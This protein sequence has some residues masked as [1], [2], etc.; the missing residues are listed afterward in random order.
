M[1]DPSAFDHYAHQ[2]KHVHDHEPG[3]HDHA[4]VAAQDEGPPSEYEIMSRAMQE[5]LEAK[6][7]ITAEEVRRRMETFEEEFP[8]RG[9]RVIAHAWTDPAF[10]KRLLKDG[11]AACAEMGVE[12]EADRLIAV[13][14]MPE[15]HNLIVCTLCSCYPR[16]LLGMP[17]TWYKSTNYRSRVVFEPRA[18][19]KEF[20]TV[21]PEHVTV[22]VHDSNADMRYVVVPMRPKGTEGWSEEQLAEI[23]TRDTLVGVTV[24][25]A[26][27]GNP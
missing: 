23:L 22:R 4:P 18:V 20:G 12:L 25:K 16:A 17:P 11:K 21:L 7:V 15:V 8:Y 10:R 6:G 14:N 9:S 24:P 27:S 1:S 13:E 19:L 26:E 2:K 3:H 5:L